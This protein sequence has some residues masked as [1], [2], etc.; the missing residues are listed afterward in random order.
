MFHLSGESWDILSGV[1]AMMVTA[2][3]GNSRI[4]A[5]TFKNY[6]WLKSSLI[7]PQKCK[8]IKPQKNFGGRILRSQSQKTTKIVEYR[9]S[10][11]KGLFLFFQFIIGNQPNVILKKTRVIISSRFGSIFFSLKASNSFP[12][13]KIQKFFIE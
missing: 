2:I 12:Q 9:K 5:Y 11:D 6:L 8:L 3:N 4:L 13:V 10:G 1:I 7:K